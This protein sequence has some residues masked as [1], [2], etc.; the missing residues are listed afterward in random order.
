MLVSDLGKAALTAPL[1]ISIAWSLI[2]SYQ[3][4]TLTAVY[5]IVRFF[6]GVWPSV[7]A[8]II[9]RIS[10]VTFI[11]AFAWIFVLSSVI[12][13]IILGKTRSVLLQFFLCLTVTLVAVSIEDILTH[14]MGTAPAAQMQSLSMWFQN[15]LVAGLYLSVPYVLMLYLDLRTRKKKPEQETVETVEQQGTAAGHQEERAQTELETSVVAA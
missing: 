8:F 4:F 2:I 1:Y 10:M 6:S 14:L 9:P 3:V 12:P 13:V 11:H 15:P 5:S 7:G